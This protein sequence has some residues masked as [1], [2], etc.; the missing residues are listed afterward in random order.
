VAFAKDNHAVFV[1]V[2][3]RIPIHV[4]RVDLTTGGRTSAADLAPPDRSGTVSARLDQ[5]ADDGRVYTYR[6][7]RSPST[8]FVVEQK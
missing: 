8:L 6:I 5:W 7:S 1:Q 2:G 4:D 3:S